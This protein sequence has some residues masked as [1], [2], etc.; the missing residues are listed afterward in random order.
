MEPNYLIIGIV[1]VIAV[2]IVIIAFRKNLKD[3]K[4]LEQTLNN[5]YFRDEELDVDANDSNSH[6]D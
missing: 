3:K 5:D 2:A 4:N 1:T 6:S